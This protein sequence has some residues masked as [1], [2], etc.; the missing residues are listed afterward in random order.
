MV[1]RRSTDLTR[2]RS[3][4]TASMHTNR[5]AEREEFEAVLQQSD[6]ITI[7]NRAPPSPTAVDYNRLISSHGAHSRQLAAGARNIRGRSV[8]P[9]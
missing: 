5:I 4:P 9:G 8:A 1:T 6:P 3:G 2:A 7:S